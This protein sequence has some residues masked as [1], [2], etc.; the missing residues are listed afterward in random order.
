M[1]KQIVS[2]KGH[3][4][5]P[6]CPH[7]G[8]ILYEENN[9]VYDCM[10]NQTD[11]KDNKNKFYAIQLIKMGTQYIVFIRYGRIGNNGVSKSNSFNSP[12]QAVTFFE[13]Q[14][15][16]KTGNSWGSAF[17]KQP[18]L[19]FFSE[20]DVA[21]SIS[22]SDTDSDSNTEEEIDL[23]KSVIKFLE[24]ISNT[25]YMTASLVELEIDIEKMPLGK[26]R[27]TQID[28]GYEILNKINKAIKKGN[29]NDLEDLSSEFYTIIPQ[30]FGRNA[31][32]IIS[33][34]KLVAKNV[35]LLNELSQMAFGA[36]TTTKLKK[37][38]HNPLLT[39]YEDL[40]TDLVPL[41]PSD[42]MFKRLADYMQRSMAPTHTFKF[43]ILQILQTDRAGERELYDA[44]SKK[45][46]NKTLLF[47]GTSISNMIGILTNGLV[48]DPSKLGINVNISGKMFGLGL[49]FANSCSKSIQYT[50]YKSSDNICC[51]FITEVALGKKLSKNQSD[52]SL[53]A[54]TMPNGYNSTWG[55]GKSSFTEY[56]LYDDN[57]QIPGGKLIK[58]NDNNRSLLYDEFI[59][60]HEEQINIKYIVLLKIK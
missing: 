53:T 37:N 25:T 42:K 22:I 9:L 18:G 4:I 6:H 8:G 44:Y 10:L 46:S 3:L 41:D 47:H 27:Q 32:P 31:P 23:D 12:S 39:L 43:D 54:K 5:D 38:K 30:V 55:R 15:K 40:N 2:T 45:I 60:Y 33:K 1:S 51:L 58:T 11:I 34:S 29:T 26:I 28:R 56:D 59:V 57:T 48:V 14:F 36:M 19:Y 21:D 17:I 35:N 16:G 24:L 52:S 50:N 13:K 20:T 7:K 49:Y